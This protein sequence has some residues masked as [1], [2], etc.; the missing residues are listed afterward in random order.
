MRISKKPIEKIFPIELEGDKF[1]VTIRQAR[2][3]DDLK[4]KDLVAETSLVINDKFL[5]QEIK[6]HIN[7]AEIQRYDIFLTMVACDLEEKDADD[8]L[9]GPYFKFKNGRLDDEAVFN[10]A[11]RWLPIEVASAIYEKVLEVNPQW[12][13]ISNDDMGE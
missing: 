1:N 7:Q 12:K 8:N 10:E 6:Q 2:V 9:I 13:F 4:R 3:G 11:Y 5:G